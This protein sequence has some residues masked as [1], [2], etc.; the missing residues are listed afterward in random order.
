MSVLQ[1]ELHEELPTESF[2]D[3]LS[4]LWEKGIRHFKASARRINRG[5]EMPELQACSKGQM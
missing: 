1:E 5:I 3:E 2:S 4:D